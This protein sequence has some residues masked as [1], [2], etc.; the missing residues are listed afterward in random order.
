MKRKHVMLL[1][2]IYLTFIA[3][4]LPDAVLNASWNLVREDLS[5]PLG[6]LGGV[7]LIIY[8]LSILSTYNAPRIMR[9]MQTKSIVWISILLTSFSL[10]AIAFAENFVQILIFGIPLGAGAGAIDVTLNHYLARNY[11]ARHMNYLH[12]FFGLGVTLGPA[13]MAYA[14]NENRWRIGFL[15]IGLILFGIALITLCSFRLWKQEETHE[16]NDDHTHVPLQTVI[17]QKGIVQSIIIFL[18]YVH[19]ESLVGVWIASYAFIDKGVDYAMAALFVTFFYLALTIGRFSSGLLSRM[20][21]PKQLIIGGEVIMILA[22]SLIFIQDMQI[23][24]YAVLVAFLGLGCAPIFPNMMFLN[25]V[26]FDKRLMSRIMSLQMAIGYLGFGVLT[27]L[28]GI[29]FDRFD[30]SLFPWFI[31]AGSVS[32]FFLTRAHIA[33]NDKNNE[34]LAETA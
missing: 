12:S 27:P 13:V 7:T 32:L 25:A 20:L 10:I 21:T 5:M 22:G 16:R 34:G 24:Y 14:L 28:V 19:V 8:I 29:V 11:Q 2:V 4:G 33:S 17:R 26:T 15:I 30:I 3:L 31:T 18:L 23:G 9:I 1:F 6:A